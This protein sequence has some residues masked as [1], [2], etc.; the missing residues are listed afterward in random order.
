[1]NNWKQIKH[2]AIYNGSEKAIRSIYQIKHVQD[3]SDENY[4]IMKSKTL[5][6]ERQTVFIDWMI[7]HNKDNISPQ[8]YL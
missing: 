2:N 3:L 8:I 7:Q 4:E 6:M 5:I 1:M